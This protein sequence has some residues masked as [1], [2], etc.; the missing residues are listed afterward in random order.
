MQ[1]AERRMQNERCSRKR[2]EGFL[3]TVEIKPVIEE[4]IKKAEPII[5]RHK[6]LMRKKHPVTR[7]ATGCESRHRF[8]ENV[9]RAKF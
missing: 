3:I 7:L 4:D 1:S 5:R 2:F 6:M 9:K 8:I